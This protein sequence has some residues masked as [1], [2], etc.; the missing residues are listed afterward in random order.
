MRG[1]LEWIWSCPQTQIKIVECVWIIKTSATAPLLFAIFLPKLNPE[2]TSKTW[3][4]NPNRFQPVDP[5]Y[6]DT[7]FSGSRKYN[8][9]IKCDLFISIFNQTLQM[10]FTILRSAGYTT[11]AVTSATI[12]QTKYHEAHHQLK[13]QR[14]A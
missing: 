8:R 1:G 13:L 5:L 12:R 14:T 2:S 3:S 11:C 6:V 4:V 10:N 9:D 7:R